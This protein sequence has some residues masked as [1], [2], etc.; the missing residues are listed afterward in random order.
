MNIRIALIVCSAATLSFAASEPKPDYS[1]AGP[2]VPLPTYRVQDYSSHLGFAWKAVVNDEKIK[3]VRFSRVAD[4]SLA[5]HAG[6]EVDDQLIAIDNHPV[7]DL[8][9]TEF[10]KLFYRDWKPGDT[11]TWDFE[12][13][14]GSLLAKRRTV[15]LRL[16]TQA[17]TAAEN[18]GGSEPAATK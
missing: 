10:Q 14:R 18:A 12:I 11:L 5:R 16:K 13:D 3:K 1:D 17:P 4:N 15:T 2:V 7:A 8:T 6:V 9:V